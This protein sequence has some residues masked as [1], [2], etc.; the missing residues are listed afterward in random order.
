MGSFEQQSNMMTLELMGIAQRM[1]GLCEKTLAQWLDTVS[2]GVI[3]FPNVADHIVN[4]VMRGDW[5][6]HQSLREDLWSQVRYPKSVQSRIDALSTVS[7]QE[8]PTDS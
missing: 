3:D 7:F 5:H 1:T 4:W 6:N 8:S 2:P